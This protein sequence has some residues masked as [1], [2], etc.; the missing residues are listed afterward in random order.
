MA[1]ITLRRKE[2]RK[3]PTVDSP[4]QIIGSRIYCYLRVSSERQ[5]KSFDRVLANMKSV[6]RSLEIIGCLMGEIFSEV[7]SAIDVQ[8]DKRPQF[9]ELMKVL[10]PGDHLIVEAKDRLDRD[11]VQMLVCLRWLE[12]RG[13]ILHCLNRNNG[14]GIEL[15]DE[16]EQMCNHF[17]AIASWHWARLNRRR[18]IEA[19]AYRRKMGYAVGG[20]VHWAKRRITLPQ[21]AH[22][23]RPY[24]KDVWIEERCMILR[25]IVRLHDKVRMPWRKL[26]IWMDENVPRKC[27]KSWES[28]KRWRPKGSRGTAGSLVSPYLFYRMAK[29]APGRPD[30]PSANRRLRNL[31]GHQGS[32]GFQG[33]WEGHD[34][35]FFAFPLAGRFGAFGA[36]GGFPV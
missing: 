25:E 27:G 5:K 9:Q 22:N 8:W 23:G 3:P 6:I 13:V 24:R 7:E 19:N 30:V 29:N 2:G 21:C 1:K 31:R 16:R 11:D 12:R 35:A 14:E 34:W 36:F 28:G 26:I 18:V 20:V 33:K 32:H 15:G 17:D 10:N 4:V